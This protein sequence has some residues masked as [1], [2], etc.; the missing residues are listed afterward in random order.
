MCTWTLESQRLLNFI[1]P[2]IRRCVRW[3]FSAS[4]DCY[5]TYSTA[6]KSAW[7]SRQLTTIWSCGS[8][9]IRFAVVS[10]RLFCDMSRCVYFA[11]T[12][13]VTLTRHRLRCRKACE[14]NEGDKCELSKTFFVR[15]FSHRLSKFFA[16]INIHAAGCWQ[17]IRQ[18]PVTIDRSGCHDRASTLWNPSRWVTLTLFDSF[19]KIKIIRVRRIILLG[20]VG[21]V[22]A[23]PGHYHDECA[24]IRTICHQ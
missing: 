20:N 14:V 2:V 3:S 13:T 11:T 8:R 4:L 12:V 15:L 23:S 10:V 1:C 6:S 7:A 24:N 17:C 5:I 22:Y 18:D 16:Y 9:E 21:A 19:L